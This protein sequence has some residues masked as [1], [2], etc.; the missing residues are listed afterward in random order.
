M[1][2]SIHISELINKLIVNTNKC[3]N[4]QNTFSHS[5]TCF[6]LLQFIFGSVTSAS[7][8]ETQMNYSINNSYALYAIYVCLFDV[9]LPE[10]DIKKTETCWSIHKLYMKVYF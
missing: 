10:N 2:Y 9:K 1:I 8:Y 6:N 4:I 3:T 7:I 5:V